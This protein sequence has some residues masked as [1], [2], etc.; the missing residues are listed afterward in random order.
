VINSVYYSQ[1]PTPIKVKKQNNL[2]FFYQ[3]DL[4][5]DTIWKYKN[6]LFY[7][8]LNDSLRHCTQ[9]LIDNGKFISTPND[10][11]IEF[12][13]MPGLKYEAKFLIENKQN[14]FQ[15][16]I[17]G[18]TQFNKNEIIIKVMSSKQDTFIIENKFYYKN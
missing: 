12:V 9:I 15:S 2:V 17:N 10:S 6:N 16:L 11:V 3:K 7:F 14:T 4:K 18:I 13:F 1:T 8:I 5:T